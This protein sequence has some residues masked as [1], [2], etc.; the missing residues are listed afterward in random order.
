[1]NITLQLSNT[2]TNLIA[3]CVRQE[4]WAQKIL[5][6]EHYSS[7]LSVCLRYTAN[8]NDAVDLMHE[9]FIK[10]FTNIHKYQP[11]TALN[12]WMKRIMV[13]RCI[14]HY[15]KMQHRQTTD[16]EKAETIQTSDADAISQFSEKEILAAIQKLPPMYQ[17]VFNLYVLEGF[18]HK[19]IAENLHI[20]EGTSR[21]NLVKARLKLKIFL[22]EKNN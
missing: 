6:E 13:N 3:A 18:S 11:D 16:I 17:T 10:I 12:A 7:M 22:L 5:Y 21:S 20:S 4:R 9:G 8:E 14:D 2:E 1:M 19:E 15:R